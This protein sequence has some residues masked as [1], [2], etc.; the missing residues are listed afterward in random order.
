M[1]AGARICC[2]ARIRPVLCFSRARGRFRGAD[3]VFLVKV[4]AVYDGRAAAVAGRRT[5]AARGRGR[6]CTAVLPC[7][8]SG[9]R[10]AYLRSRVGGL[11][12]GP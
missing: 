7:A 8:A 6:G 11:Q 9:P 2:R 1:A 12:A 3:A 5:I 10:A 4:C